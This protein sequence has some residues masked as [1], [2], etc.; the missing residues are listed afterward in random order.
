MV[1]GVL[2][3]LLTSDTLPLTLP[4]TVGANF[5]WNVALCPAAMVVGNVSPL[6]LNPAPVTF[7]WLMVTLAE[8]AVTVTF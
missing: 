1:V 2:E 4:A 6:T 8:L 7:A 5:T 3:A